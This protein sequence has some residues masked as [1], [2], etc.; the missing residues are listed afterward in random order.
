MIWNS[1][2][3]RALVWTLP[4]INNFVHNWN[5]WNGSRVVLN[6]QWIVI[7]EIFIAI[8]L[9]KNT[10]TDILNVSFSTLAVVWIMSRKL[11]YLVH[12]HKFLEEAIFLQGHALRKW[13]VVITLWM[14]PLCWN[15]FQSCMNEL[16]LLL[17]YII[18]NVW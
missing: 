7:V 3:R 6:Y 12:L 17:F 1:S 11:E 8:Y 5:L 10:R 15:G 2:Q 13:I 9:P 16:V 18:C 14:H 4:L